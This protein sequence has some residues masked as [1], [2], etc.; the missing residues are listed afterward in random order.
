MSTVRAQ[1]PP[2]GSWLWRVV[3]CDDQGKVVKV[4]YG[5]VPVHLTQ[6]AAAEHGASL[7]AIKLFE[8][9][10]HVVSDLTVSVWS[11][12]RAH[13]GL[14]RDARCGLQR[15]GSFGAENQVPPERKEKGGATR[16]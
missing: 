1:T 5:N 9:G 12:H 14:W 4:A 11:C 16:S 6:P 7:L 10:V 2:T 8:D 13:G 15:R 3:Q